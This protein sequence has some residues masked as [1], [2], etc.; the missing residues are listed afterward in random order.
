[1]RGVSKPAPTPEG[2]VVREVFGEGIRAR[3]VDGGREGKYLYV[4]GDLGNDDDWA[5][6]LEVHRRLP[7]TEAHVVLAT[8]EEIREGGKPPWSILK[9]TF[10]I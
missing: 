9:R 3:W 6:L 1:M 7:D 2:V 10:R 8:I 4:E 5:K